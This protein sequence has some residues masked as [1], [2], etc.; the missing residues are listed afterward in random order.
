VS[1]L[2]RAKAA[3]SRGDWDEARRALEPLHTAE[4]S[5]PATFLL[6]RTELESGNPDV[7]AALLDDLLSGRPRHERARALRAQI[8]LVAGD[9]AR[10]RAEAE[11]ALRTAPG[12]VVARRVLFDV[13]VAEKL[14]G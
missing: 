3:L 7:A 5:G 6:A 8:H 1:K 11:E 13:S 9:P 14:R 12:L 10:A 2:D 4:P